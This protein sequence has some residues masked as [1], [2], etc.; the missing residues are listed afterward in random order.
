MTT[1]K[2][3]IGDRV[4][5]ECDNRAWVVIGVQ[6]RP[7]YNLICWEYWLGRG[8]YGDYPIG[9]FGNRCDVETKGPFREEQLETESGRLLRKKQELSELIQETEKRLKELKQEEEQT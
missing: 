8:L 1:H 3:N 4:Y 2:F 9:A 5:I 6:M 7:S